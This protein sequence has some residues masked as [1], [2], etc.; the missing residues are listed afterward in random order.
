LAYHLCAN[1]PE[2]GVEINL[3]PPHEWEKYKREIYEEQGWATRRA[4]DRTIKALDELPQ[5]IWRESG[6]L[7]GNTEDYIK[8]VSMN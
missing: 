3:I 8:L 4:R 6:E 2:Y 7:I 1:L 5:L